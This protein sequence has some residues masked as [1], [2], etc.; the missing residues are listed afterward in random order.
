MGALRRIVQAAR[1]SGVCCN[2]L[3][4]S[5]KCVGSRLLVAR[6]HSWRLLGGEGPHTLASLLCAAGVWWVWHRVVCWATHVLTVITW[7]V[8]LALRD[9]WCCC[10]CSLDSG[11]CRMLHQGDR[12]ILGMLFPLVTPPGHACVAVS[13]W[14]VFVGLNWWA[15]GG[16]AA[17]RAWQ[18]TPGVL[19]CMLSPMKGLLALVQVVGSIKVCGPVCNGDLNPR[20]HTHFVGLCKAAV[21][22]PATAACPACCVV[23]AA[24]AGLLVGLQFV[25]GHYTGKPNASGLCRGGAMPPNP[26]S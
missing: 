21:L 1:Q 9:Y 4:G 2:L 23:L 25:V 20:V 15:A 8:G 5:G 7:V 22:A 16:P 19:G 3:L 13:C 6:D 14:L 26:C 10:T 12:G 17:G 18:A 24:Q 11:S